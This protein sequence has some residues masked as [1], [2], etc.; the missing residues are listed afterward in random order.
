MLSST[1]DRLGRGRYRP[2]NVDAEPAY[3]ADIWRA[4]SRSAPVG[5]TEFRSTLLP[6][7]SPMCRSSAGS[8][9]ESG[10]TFRVKQR[11][12]RHK[13]VLRRVTDRDNASALYLGARLLSGFTTGN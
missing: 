8:C 6:A 4:V 13:P 7:P 11:T 1:S 5:Q 12:Y 10:V 9:P 2:G 3:V